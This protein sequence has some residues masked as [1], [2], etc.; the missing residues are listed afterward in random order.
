V[1]GR[2]LIVDDHEIVRQGVRR[3][4]ESQDDWEV[5]GEAA[6]GQQAIR[7]TKELEPD[8]IVMD[9]TMPVMSGLEATSE[10][11][12][13]NPGSKVL[14]FTMHES[15]TLASTIRRSGAKGLLSKAKA[16]MELSPALQAIIEGQTYFH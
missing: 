1:P 13:S 5:V 8:A 16:A 14:V 9:I 11:T 2:I 3:I 6:D 15:R 7:L 4:L 10:I 12:K